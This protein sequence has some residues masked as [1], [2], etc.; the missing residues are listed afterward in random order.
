VGEVRGVNRGLVFLGVPL[1]MYVLQ[2]ATV[3]YSAGRYGMTLA[4]LAYALANVG[5]I[6]DLYGI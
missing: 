4:M 1:L 5:L 6:L 3:Y 2:G